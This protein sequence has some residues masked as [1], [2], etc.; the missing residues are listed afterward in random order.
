MRRI[1]RPAMCAGVVMAVALTAGCGPGG[2]DA[3]GLAD[4]V[5]RIADAAAADE[6]ADSASDGASGGTSDN[7]SGGGP[8]APAAGA[9]PDDWPDEFPDPP[10]GVVFNGY[11]GAAA[12][13]RSEYMAT[14]TLADGDLGDVHAYYLDALATAG[15]EQTDGLSVVSSNTAMTP[16]TG[17]DAEGSVTVQQDNSDAPVTITIIMH[18]QR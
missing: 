18:I 8:G 1:W 7:D 10:A 16:F 12:G 4:L 14:Y 3:D 9:L 11:L 2:D 13:D 17:Y 6:D 5:D 15:W